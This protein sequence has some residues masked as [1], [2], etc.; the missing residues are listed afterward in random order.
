M[1]KGV[2]Y[3]RKARVSQPPISKGKLNT[4]ELYSKENEVKGG[5]KDKITRLSPLYD[6][7][8]SQQYSNASLLQTDFSASMHGNSV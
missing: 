1:T 5:E 6:S 4:A 7:L 2:A 3:T 8:L